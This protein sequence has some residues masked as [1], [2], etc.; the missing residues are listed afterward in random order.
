MNKFVRV[1]FQGV[2][3]VIFPL[4]RPAEYAFF[5]LPAVPYALV[6]YIPARVVEPGNGVFAVGI[7]GAVD[8]PAGQ[9]AC[10][11]RNG[12]AE[13]L[14][15]E[16]MVQR[17]LQLFLKFFLFGCQRFAE[18]LLRIHGLDPLL[19][20]GQQ[21]IKQPLGDLP[22][23]HAGFAGGIYKNANFDTNRKSLIRHISAEKGLK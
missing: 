11:L 3:A 2:I 5:V 23:E 8:A 9:K 20:A 10:K 6:A 21:P 7:F 14:F 19:P 1:S 13:E 22:Q 15:M 4:R 16:N 18:A 17:A 12:D